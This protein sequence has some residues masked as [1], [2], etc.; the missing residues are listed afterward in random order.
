MNDSTRFAESDPRHHTDKIRKMLE[1][2]AEHARS[3]VSKIKD[4]KA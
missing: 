3:D 2:V 1:D 4:S